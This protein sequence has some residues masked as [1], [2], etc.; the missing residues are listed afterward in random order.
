MNKTRKSCQNSSQL[1]TKVVVSVFY[2]N[3]NQIHSYSFCLWSSPFWSFSCK[4]SSIHILAVFGWFKKKWNKLSFQSQAYICAGRHKSCWG[5]LYF[6][7]PYLSH[8]DHKHSQS[9]KH[10]NSVASKE[11][12]RKDGDRKEIIYNYEYII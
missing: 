10:S 12:K 9:G 5:K 3:L 4:L 7:S 6:L 8:K 1:V 11:K 2:S